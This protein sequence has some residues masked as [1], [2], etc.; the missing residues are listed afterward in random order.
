M[1]I[2]LGKI[3][4]WRYLKTELY[5]N[6]KKRTVAPDNYKDIYFAYHAN[7]KYYPKERHFKNIHSQVSPKIIV[8]HI[9]NIIVS[10]END[11]NYSLEE[12][13]AKE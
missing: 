9:S 6:W 2:G 4:L 7:S 10:L 12:K 8:K 3:D 11:K 13:Y 1:D 5:N